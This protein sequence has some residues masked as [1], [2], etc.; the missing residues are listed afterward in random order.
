MRWALVA[1]SFAG[2][3][4]AQNADLAL[5]R[6]VKTAVVIGE[7]S[8]R[9]VARAVALDRSPHSVAVADSAPAEIHVYKESLQELGLGPGLLELAESGRFG[10]PLP[11]AALVYE[12]SSDHAEVTLDPAPARVW[13][14]DR[15]E[16][17]ASC[18]RM[19]V[20]TLTGT[21]SDWFTDAVVL[22]DGSLL[23]TQ[24]DGNAGQFYRVTLDTMTSLPLPR[25]LPRDAAVQSKDGSIWLS[26]C[27]T[28]RLARLVPVDPA[29]GAFEVH[30]DAACPVDHV[31]DEFP[32]VRL[33]Q[34]E[35]PDG[36]EQRFG[37]TRG[38]TLIRYDEDRGIPIAEFDVKPFY[39]DF[40]EWIGP[41]ATVTT[42]SKPQ[43]IWWH[44]GQH[45]RITP[46][47]DESRDELTLYR[48]ANTDLGVLLLGDAGG[49]TVLLAWDPARGVW[50]VIDIFAAPGLLYDMRPLDGG[51]YAV[52]GVAG[53]MG[54]FSMETG[55]CQVEDQS[56][57][58]FS[59]YA[60]TPAP[61]DRA[62]ILGSAAD[63]STGR[64]V[65]WLEVSR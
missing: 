59:F 37:L 44:D 6:E 61:G 5:P 13:L 54:Y 4:D 30:M 57:R 43:M 2:C 1:V 18:P 35:L 64:E 15:R 45:E 25:E 53:S 28:R 23:V 56:L 55:Y 42:I 8:G 34:G 26:G 12:S 10:R 63:N 51:G 50:Y 21:A 65:W 52:A 60:V 58:E 46:K 48:A 3:L 16:R 62:L 33:V 24:A 31:H 27:M 49:R 38:T 22:A 39:F 7:V 32:V 36:T 20:H 47:F 17:V 11:K 41:D 14:A 29:T 19:S 9:R 40:M